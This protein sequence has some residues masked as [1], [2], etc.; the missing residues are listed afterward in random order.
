L[1]VGSRPLGESGVPLFGDGFDGRAD[2]GEI[3]EEVRG[4]PSASASSGLISLTCSGPFRFGKFIDGSSSNLG[5][6]GVFSG[7][8]G[9]T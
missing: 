7:C 4:S 9:I 1:L 5:S 3:T 2:A 6:S 8:F